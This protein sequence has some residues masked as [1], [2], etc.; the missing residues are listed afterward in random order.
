MERLVSRVTWPVYH[1]LGFQTL[2]LDTAS[3]EKRFETYILSNHMLKQNKTKPRHQIC[4]F[5]VNNFHCGLRR[6]KASSRT[7]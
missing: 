6:P 5:P 4:G 3:L 7:T 2:N 1:R